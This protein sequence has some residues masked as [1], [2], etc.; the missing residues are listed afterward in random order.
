MTPIKLPD[1]IRFLEAKG[2]SR[3]CP[4]CGHDKSDLINEEGAN[5][6]FALP[7]FELG[8]YD[9][10]RADMLG[11]FVITCADCGFV[12]LFHRAKIANWV[13][14]NPGTDAG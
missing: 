2:V 14:R 7:G 8:G 3:N 5:L 6:H 12:R 1:A 11:L 9:F 13:E 10:S 4:A